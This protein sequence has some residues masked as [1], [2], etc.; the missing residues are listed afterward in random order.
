MSSNGKFYIVTDSNNNP[1]NW[2]DDEHQYW[3]DINLVSIDEVR[4]FEFS[5]EGLST[6]KC[7]VEYYNDQV[8]VDVKEFRGVKMPLKVNVM[9]SSRFLTT[10][11]QD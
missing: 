10:E 3:W 2:K 11:F 8:D 6:A 9:M 5:E 4:V 1:V 7:I